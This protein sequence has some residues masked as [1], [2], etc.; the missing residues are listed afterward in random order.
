MKVVVNVV[1]EYEMLVEIWK[2]L[3]VFLK[4]VLINMRYFIVI[5]ILL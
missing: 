1:M 2:L 4:K 3:V 5:F